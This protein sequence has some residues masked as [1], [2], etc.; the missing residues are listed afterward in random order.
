MVS[1]SWALLATLVVAAMPAISDYSREFVF[2]V[3]ATLFFTGT[4]WALLRS[5]RLRRPRWVWTAAVFV[6]FMTLSRTMTVS[7]LPAIALIALGQLFA[8]REELRRR[9]LRLLAGAGIATFVAASW[10]LHNWRGVWDYLRTS[11]YGSAAG[12]YGQAHSILS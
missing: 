9:A 5:D 3:P 10:F 6:G 8:S 4:L 12:Q 1:E 7:F 2:A 11:G